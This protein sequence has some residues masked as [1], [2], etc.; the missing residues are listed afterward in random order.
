MKKVKNWNQVV[1]YVLLAA[2]IIFLVAQQFT[3]TSMETGNWECAQTACSRLMT[4]QEIAASVCAEND[5]GEMIC[6]VNID[7]EETLVPLNQLNLTGLS[8]CA[9][10]VCVKEAKVR[11]VSYPVNVTFA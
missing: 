2:T 6:S 1:V 5:D 10:Y 4:E 8:F 3:T 7:G 9:E 11:D